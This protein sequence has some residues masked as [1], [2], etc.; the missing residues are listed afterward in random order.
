MPHARCHRTS[1]ASPASPMDHCVGCPAPPAPKR[2]KHEAPANSHTP[3]EGAD[4]IPT[5]P[6]VCPVDTVPV[7]KLPAVAPKEVIINIGVARC[8][9]NRD[10]SLNF[11][12][13]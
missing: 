5:P 11:G 9:E 4:K 10:G 2:I 12:I 3:L 13:K 6:D 1:N 7:D 8:I